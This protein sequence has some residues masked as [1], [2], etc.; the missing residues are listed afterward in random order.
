MRDSELLGLMVAAADCGDRRGL[1]S[2]LRELQVQNPA[3][4]EQARAAIMKGLE[5]KS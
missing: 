1:V 4:A 2:I 3:V 5:A